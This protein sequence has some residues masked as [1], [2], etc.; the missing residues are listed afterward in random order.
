MPPEPSLPRLTRE[1]MPTG[2][3]PDRWEGIVGSAVEMVG[4]TQAREILEAR[5]E[6][7]DEY[8]EKRARGLPAEVAGEAGR[9]RF[10]SVFQKRYS[11]LPWQLFWYRG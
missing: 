5:I 11:Y 6:V 9:E 3:D 7:R 4:P 1:S 10:D 2:F 8:R